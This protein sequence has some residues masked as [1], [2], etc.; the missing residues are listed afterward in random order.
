MDTVRVCAEVNSGRKNPLPHYGLEPMS[1]LLLAFQSG[2]LPTE[3]SLP[4]ESESRC[5]TTSIC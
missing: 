2:S 1:V 4:S 3:L 5:Y